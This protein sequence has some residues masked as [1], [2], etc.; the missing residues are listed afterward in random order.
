MTPSMLTS[1]IAVAADL[2]VDRHPDPYAVF[3]P[4]RS[5]CD[6]RPGTTQTRR[7]VRVLPAAAKSLA[8]ASAD[9]RLSVTEVSA[10]DRLAPGSPLSAP[11][12]GHTERA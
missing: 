10:A 8:A 4:P 9:P 6:Y 12:D 7:T 5:Q 11:S 3:P 1:T 2:Q